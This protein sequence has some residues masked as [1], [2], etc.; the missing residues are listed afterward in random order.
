MFFLDESGFA[1]VGCRSKCQIRGDWP[2]DE[3]TTF[4][5][6][7]TENFVHVATDTNPP[8]LAFPSVEEEPLFAQK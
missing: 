1:T 2:P 7:V 4:P 3:L 5:S 6:L 8:S